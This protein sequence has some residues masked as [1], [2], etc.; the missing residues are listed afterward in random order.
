LSISQLRR[1]DGYAP[2]RSGGKGE[3]RKNPRQALHLPEDPEAT[4]DGAEQ[5][6]VT[7]DVLRIPKEE[8]TARA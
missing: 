2:V 7:R 1:I 8:E 3:I 4:V 6:A 5:L